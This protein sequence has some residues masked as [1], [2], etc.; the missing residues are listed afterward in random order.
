LKSSGEQFR[1][2]QFLSL[3]SGQKG[4]IMELGLLIEGAVRYKASDIHLKEGEPPYFRVD[5]DLLP[6]QKQPPLTH[7]NIVKYV[8]ELV[9][10][11]LRNKLEA[12]RGIDVGY[13]YKDLVRCRVIVFYQRRKLAVSLRLLPIEPPTILE[14]DL[15]PTLAR[16]VDYH[17]GMIL[18]TGPTGSGKSTTMASMIDLINSTQAVSITTVEDPIE[19]VYKNKKAYITQREVGDDVEDFLSGSIQALRQDP[20]IVLVGEMRSLETMRAGIYSAETGHLF[21]STLHTS[22]AIQAMERMIGTFPESEHALVLEQLAMNL[23]VVMTQEL[24]RRAEGR[25]RIAAMEILVV[26]DLVAKLILE[27]R[28]TDIYEVMKK[29]EEGMQ[30]LDQALADFV[31]DGKIT[32]E[33]GAK[34]TRD[35]HAYHRYILHKESSSDLGGVLR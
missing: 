15:P 30:T 5:H 9:P 23:K 35:V 6:V 34:Y 33:E 1:S 16:F 26:T 10:E 19:Y 13:Q 2:D 4:S 7:E 12:K 21:M 22:S 11:R 8:E 20:D 17:R 18:V 3:K 24:V 25:G 31:R 29:R 27:N 32:E 14:L 28:I